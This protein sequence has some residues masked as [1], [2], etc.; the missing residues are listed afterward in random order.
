MGRHKLYF[1]STEKMIGRKFI[2]FS[3]FF[4]FAI[5]KGLTLPVEDKTKVSLIPREDDSGTDSDVG[6]RKMVD[7]RSDVDCSGEEHL[8]D[9]FGGQRKRFR[10]SGGELK[11][12]VS[13]I[14][15][16]RGGRRGRRR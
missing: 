9:Q 10:R 13:I 6:I 11:S 12:H 16:G 1:S 4:L 15:G 5:E 3:F 14:R 7:F 8:I 2:L